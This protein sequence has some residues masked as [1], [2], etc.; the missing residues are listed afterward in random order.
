MPTVQLQQTPPHIC[1]CQKADI[2][3]GVE[4]FMCDFGHWL[5]RRGAKV[6]IL[7]TCPA[8]FDG[9]FDPGDHVQLVEGLN[10]DERTFSLRQMFD[11]YRLFRNIR[12][13]FVLFSHTRNCTFLNSVVGAWLAG[14]RVIADYYHNIIQVDPAFANRSILPPRELWAIRAKIYFKTV[15]MFSTAMVF[16]N[17]QSMQTAASA[18]DVSD[19]KFHFIPLGVD[20]RRFSQIADSRTRVRAELQIPS[21]GLVF[22]V[23]CRLHPVKGLTTLLKAFAATCKELPSK[24]FYCVLI[25]DGP[26][27][28]ELEQLA[29]ELHVEEKVRFVGHVANPEIYLN[30]LD[31]FAM[32]SD[33]EPFGLAL[34]EGMATELPCIA[35]RVGEIPSIITDEHDGLLVD[36]GDWQAAAALFVRLANDIELCR[37]LGSEARKTSI[38]K[39][40]QNVVWTKLASLM[41]LDLASLS[42]VS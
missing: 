31:V 38:Q 25:G 4:R 22:G 32:L 11:A 20:V 12:P 14:T 18:F 15:A 27:R 2:F 34:L 1:L 17:R 16:N 29:R 10:F 30:A 42:D 6:T 37:R 23:A 33:I 28:Q 40:Q 9:H 19:N 36:A 35:T 5:A 13:D 7:S 21:T 24:N 3:G 39:Y 41:N 26:M 8:I